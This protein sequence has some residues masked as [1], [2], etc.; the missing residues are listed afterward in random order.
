V[1]KATRTTINTEIK[2]STLTMVINR[3]G[4]AL[5]EC[6]VTHEEALLSIGVMFF[7]EQY[8]LEFEITPDSMGDFKDIAKAFY[9]Q[10]ESNSGV[11]H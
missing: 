9:Q 4:D 3:L 7:L 2:D 1:D 10:I 11:V 5:A 6:G 8:R